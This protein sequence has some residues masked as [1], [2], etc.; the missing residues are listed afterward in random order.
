MGLD[1]DLG[2]YEI[3]RV[4]GQKEKIEETGKQ[5]PI[6]GKTAWM[7]YAPRTSEDNSEE[8]FI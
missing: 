5:L 7:G 1:I 2:F 8:I 4:F 3:R 6:R